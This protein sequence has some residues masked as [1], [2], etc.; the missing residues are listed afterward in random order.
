MKCNE[1]IRVRYEEYKRMW[2]F[3]LIWGNFMYFVKKCLYRRIEDIVRD[4][5]SIIFEDVEKVGFMISNE[6]R[7]Y[8]I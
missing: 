3:I 2:C 6:V 4:I 8:F 7:F 5:V 1:V